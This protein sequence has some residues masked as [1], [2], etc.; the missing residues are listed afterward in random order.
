[1][2]A[3]V[4]LLLSLPCVVLGSSCAWSLCC[5]VAAVVAAGCS[6]WFPLVAAVVAA[7]VAAGC[8]F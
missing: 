7:V 2:I 4:V 8:S 5:S 6:F 3:S 1:M